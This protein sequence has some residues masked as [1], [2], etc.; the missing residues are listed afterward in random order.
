[1]HTPYDEGDPDIIGQFRKRPVH[2]GPDDW[3]LSRLKFM[4]EQ[5]QQHVTNYGRISEL[6]NDYDS[7][8]NEADR[9]V[10]QIVQE[11]KDSG[12]WENAL[13]IVT[14]DHGESFAERGIHIGHGLSLTDDELHVPLV[15][16]LPH[17][18]GAGQRLDTQVDLLDVAP[19][20][21]AYAGVPAPRE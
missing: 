14:S 8:T 17:D 15:M 5:N 6:L 1:V 16:H 4:Y 2:D 11:L 19:T 9:G 20:V 7:G 21:L 13:L 12:R 10:G 3:E 18:E